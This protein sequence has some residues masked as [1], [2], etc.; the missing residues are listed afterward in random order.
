MPVGGLTTRGPRNLL[1]QI[2]EAMAGA[3]PAQERLDMVVRTIAQSMVAEVCSIYLRRASGELELFATQGLNPEAVHKTRLRP[4]EGLVG[5]VARTAAP[6]SLSDAPSH[7][8]FAYRPETGEDPYHAFLGAPLLRGG[9]AI[10]VL[11][12]QNRSERRYDEE[13]VEDIQTIAMV[14]AETVASGELLAQDELRD[15]EVAP[16]RPERLKGQRFAEGL[17]YGHVILHEAPV[18]PENL[19]AENQQVEEIRLREALIGLKANID[20]ILDGGQG[21]L[22]GQSFEV[23]ETYRMFADDR[24]WNRSLEEAVRTG[25]TA[26]AAVD[27]VRNEHRARFAQARDPYIKERLHDFEDL[28][29]RLLRVLAGDRPGER[30]LPD[31]AILVARNLGPADLLEYPRHKLRGLLLEEGSAASHAAIV[32]RAL[33]I[34]CVGRIMGLRDRLSEGD[35]VIV[36]GETGETYL[37]PRPDMLAA[38]QSRMLVRSERQAEFAKLRDVPAVTL[39]GTRITLLTNA[40]LAVD[41]ENLDATGAEGIGLFRTEFQFM[42]SEELPRLN[43]QTALYKL[44]LDTAGD[45]PVIFRTLDIGGDKVLPYLETEREENPALGRRAIRLGLDRPGLLRLQLRALLTAA[46]GRELRVMFPM[47]AT[48]DEFRAAREL[49]DVECAWAKRRGRALP[50]LLRVGAMIEC[51]SLL[52]HLD[53]LLPLTDFVS[54][55]TNDLFQYMFAADR[56][57]P[58]VSERYDPLSP[59]ALRALAE[60]QKKCADTGTPV[61]VCGELAGKPL[62]AFALLTLG[63]TRLSAPAGG[64]GPVKRMILSADLPAARRGMTNLLGSSAGSIRGELESLARKLNVTI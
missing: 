37:R 16:H 43:S 51:P 31:D 7:P 41:L 54:I 6:I 44:V 52:W 9:R 3:A 56:T 8:S 1:R 57:N 26:E 21:K 62:E 2:R 13:E 19:L 5:E 4:G 40:G 42:V 48:V 49:V 14:L 25:L 30:D 33:Q 34:P 58:L 32:A 53:A 15:I 12:V 60:I 64:V 50:A 20:S 47:I 10:G 45:R 39:D 36:D 11:V 17:A 38:V 55:G 22:A 61:S 35:L 63:F 28:A 59:P 18:P 27:R 23:L 46:A 29:N 24:G